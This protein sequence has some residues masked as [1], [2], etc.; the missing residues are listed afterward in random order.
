MG[1]F[2]YPLAIEAEQEKRNHDFI[3]SITTSGDGIVYARLT[4]FCRSKSMQNLCPAAAQI[5]K[6]GPLQKKTLFSGD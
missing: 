5:F 6:G 3:G 1:I 4:D 2:L